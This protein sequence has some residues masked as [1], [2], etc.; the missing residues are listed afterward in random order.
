M[1]NVNFYSKIDLIKYPVVTDKATRLLENNSYTFIVDPKARKQEIKETIEFL[2]NVKVIKVNTC[3]M[4]QK[5]RR[6]GKYSGTRPHYKKAI[7]KLA[8]GNTINLFSEN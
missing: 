2:F 6:V 5:K 8:P 4:A 7:V 1:S 3:H